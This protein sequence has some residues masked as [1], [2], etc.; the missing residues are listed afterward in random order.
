MIHRDDLVAR[1]AKMLTRPLRKWLDRT[2]EG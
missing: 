2:A 1:E